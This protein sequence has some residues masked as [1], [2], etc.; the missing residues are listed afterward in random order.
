MEEREFDKGVRV[1]VPV[2]TF[3]EDE[4]RLLEIAEKLPKL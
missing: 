2:E 1:T 3:S 4:L